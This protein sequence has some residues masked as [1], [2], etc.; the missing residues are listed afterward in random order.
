MEEKQ[1]LNNFVIKEMTGEYGSFLK[2]W[3][4]DVDKLHNEL[5]ELKE[6]KSVNLVISKRK[7]KSEKG[8]THY[9][10]KDTFK[11]DQKKSNDQS[12]NDQFEED[13]PF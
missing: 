10:Y 5:N 12:N 6:D 2:V 8:V 9:T 1:Y 13:V 4:P 3:I 7:E 11:P